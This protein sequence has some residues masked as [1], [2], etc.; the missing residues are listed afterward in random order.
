MCLTCYGRYEVGYLID[1]SARTY[2]KAKACFPLLPLS[3]PIF[4]KQKRL[5]VFQSM[6]EDMQ[7]VLVADFK[8]WSSVVVIKVAIEVVPRFPFYQG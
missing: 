6:I 8:I 4:L 3:L 7:H 2:L 1:T 5:L